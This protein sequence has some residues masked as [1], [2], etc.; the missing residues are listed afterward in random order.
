MGGGDV[1]EGDIRPP[2]GAVTDVQ[3]ALLSL[4]MIPLVTVQHGYTLVD[5]LEGR[6]GSGSGRQTQ[7][8]QVWFALP[9]RKRVRSLYAHVCM[10][11]GGSCV[12]GSLLTVSRMQ[13]AS[14]GR[15]SKRKGRNARATEPPRVRVADFGGNLQVTVECLRDPRACFLPMQKRGAVA[16]V[17]GTEN[18][19]GGVREGERGGSGGSGDWDGE[20]QRLGCEKLIFERPVFLCGSTGWLVRGIT[21]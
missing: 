16:G 20:G 6:D 19:Q 10:D 15:S 13:G 7:V 18:C 17:V 8:L 14:A 3:R 4:H 2:G 5:P 1:V 9:A 21:R 12:S 11:A